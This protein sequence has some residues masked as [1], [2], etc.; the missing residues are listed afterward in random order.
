[1][2]VFMTVKLQVYHSLLDWDCLSPIIYKNSKVI[3]IHLTALL[4]YMTA[5]LEYL[6][7]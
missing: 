7:L 2:S 1:V 4:K 3:M 5:L 6:E